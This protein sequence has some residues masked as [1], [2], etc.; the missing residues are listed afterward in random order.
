[1]ELGQ[2]VRFDVVVRNTGSVA[3]QNAEVRYLWEQVGQG[4]YAMTARWS[5]GTCADGTC[6]LGTLPANSEI[7]VSVEGRTGDAYNWVGP[8]S[9][10]ATAAADN[11]NAVSASTRVD[12]VRTVLS[13]GDEGGGGAS[14]PFLMFVLLL[15]V[16]RRR[17]SS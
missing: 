17:S 3:A 5:G 11:A 12:T 6:N 2:T 4:S 9:L 8:F 14:G 10:V 1:M 15:V 13:I 16:L 7:V